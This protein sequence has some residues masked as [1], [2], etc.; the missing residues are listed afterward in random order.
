[1]VKHFFMYQYILDLKLSKDNRYIFYTLGGGSFMNT[2]N[3]K[4]NFY[5]VDTKTKIRINV[6]RFGYNDY[7]C[8]FD[9]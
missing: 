8:G 7:F 3:Y 4:Y 5:I 2:C 6:K 1:M 9:W